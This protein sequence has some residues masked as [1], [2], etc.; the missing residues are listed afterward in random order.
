MS[1]VPQVEK[2]LLSL[3]QVECP[4]SHHFGPGIYIREVTMPAGA[5]VVGHAQKEQHLNSMVA[6]RVVTFFDGEIRELAAPMVFESGAG[7]KA[8]QILETTV[9][10]NI[11]STDE[12]D[13]NRLEARFLDKSDA[14]L[15]HEQ[16]LL[17]AEIIK[18]DQED[19]RRSIS[20]NSLSFGDSSV[21]ALPVEFDRVATVRNSPI[22]GKGLFLNWSV[23]PGTVLMPASILGDI[24][25]GAR[26]V[27]HS[28]NPNCHYIEREGIAYLV[29]LRSIRGNMGGSPG[30]ELTVNYRNTT[31][32]LCQA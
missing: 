29:S 5:F 1:L 21:R 31:R 8:M 16:S 25:I 7:R 10:Q 24:T 13:I 17:C 22:H 26:Y 12:K 32:L 15:E 19:F 2:A 4:V 9:W 23:D 20:N 30:E 11:Y 3:P 6:G 18:R 14:Y 27:N 28:L